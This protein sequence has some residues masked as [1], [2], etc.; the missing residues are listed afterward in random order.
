MAARLPTRDK[1]SGF[2]S[3][4]SLP[5][6]QPNY[7]LI[8]SYGTLW[9]FGGKKAS[10][11]NF[12][13]SVGKINILQSILLQSGECNIIIFSILLFNMRHSSHVVCL[14]AIERHQDRHHKILQRHTS[15]FSLPWFPFFW[16]TFHN[17]NILRFFWVKKLP[18]KYMVNE[19]ELI[20]TQQFMKPCKY[21]LGLKNNT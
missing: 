21:F 14:S 2:N 16:D 1:T 10:Y 8:W 6:Y 12:K 4:E 11:C 13:Y 3:S 18:Y 20:S 7:L 19:G 5:S 15:E 17:H 9:F